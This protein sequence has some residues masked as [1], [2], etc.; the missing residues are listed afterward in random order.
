MQ[1]QQITLGPTPMFAGD[2]ITIKAGP[3][4]ALRVL[5]DGQTYDVTTGDSGK[6]EFV[7]PASGAIFVSDPAGV[8]QTATDVVQP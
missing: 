8:W 7:L 5:L 2:T 4:M 3:N 6:V 1:T